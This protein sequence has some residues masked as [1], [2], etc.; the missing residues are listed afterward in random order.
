MGHENRKSASP[1]L[2][3]G[4]SPI[5][6]ILA[7]VFGIALGLIFT[8]GLYLITESNSWWIYLPVPVAAAAG[9]WK[10]DRA[11]FTMLRVLGNL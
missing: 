7:G 4:H 9:Y 6:R 2:W 1:P 10:G 3:T 5:Q 8:L 11:L